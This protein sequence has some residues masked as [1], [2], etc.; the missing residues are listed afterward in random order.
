[1]SFGS[2]K[3]RRAD[4]LSGVRD[5]MDSD[6][7]TDSKSVP[8]ASERA[9]KV[10]SAQAA[11]AAVIA[12]AAN[13]T[14]DSNAG[15]QVIGL[16]YTSPNN[17]QGTDSS[18]PSRSKYLQVPGRTT[19][20]VDS[21]TL[22]ALQVAQ[23][24]SYVLLEDQKELG[25]DY[26][27]FTRVETV[28]WRILIPPTVVASFRSEDFGLMLKPKSESDIAEV[29]ISTVDESAKEAAMTE[30]PEIEETIVAHTNQVKLGQE[31]T[32]RPIEQLGSMEV[33][34]QT[35]DVKVD[36]EEMDELEED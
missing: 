24:S 2:S 32:T 34:Y 16:N 28:G 25:I 36:E 27:T 17:E 35:L 12:A 13:A 26:S 31:D 7:A 5:E 29:A 1:M 23:A 20:T 30:H 9:P 21:P 18:Q 3:K 11:A 15:L 4:S 14:A 19:T 22:E 6:E 33:E 10:A 8:S